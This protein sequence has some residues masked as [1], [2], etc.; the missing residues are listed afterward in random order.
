M[1][2]SECAGYDTT[3]KAYLTAIQENTAWVYGDA[4]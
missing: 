2:V 4:M 1:L 3:L